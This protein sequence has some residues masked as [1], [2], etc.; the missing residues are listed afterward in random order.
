MN[1]G[2]VL[3]LVVDVAIAEVFLVIFQVFRASNYGKESGFQF[4]RV[5][6]SFSEAGG[7]RIFRSMFSCYSL[8]L[9]IV[10]VGPKT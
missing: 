5:E 8:D 10:P 9:G 6:R 4:V 3:G 1:S 7:M 2:C